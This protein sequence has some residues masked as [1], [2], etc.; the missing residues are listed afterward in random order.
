VLFEMQQRLS[1]RLMLSFGAFVRALLLESFTGL[2]GHSLPRRLVS[3]CCP[4]HFGGL[5]GPDLSTLPRRWVVER[6]NGW[7]NHCRRID[8]H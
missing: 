6:S 8:R 7:I 3:H 4:A 1:R 2:L 5:V